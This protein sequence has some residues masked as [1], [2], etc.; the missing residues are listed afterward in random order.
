MSALDWFL[1]IVINGAIVAFGLWHARNTRNSVDWFLGAKS[2]PWW[3]V[4]LS[5]FA[6]AVDS[7]DYVAVAGNAYKDGLIY[8]SAWWLGLSIGWCTV[9][10]LVFL[11]M[12]RA[13]MY[14]NV[15]YLEFRFGPV[16]R[17]LSV[18]IQIQTRT[19]VMGIV[20]YS[21]FLTFSS[22]TGWGQN[23]WWL[24][25]GIAIGAAAYTA[26]GGVKSV[27]L[28][29][30]IQ[31]VVMLL[32]AVVLWWTV[33]SDVGGWSGLEIKLMEHIETGRLAADTG[34]AMTHVGEY[35]N[36]HVPPGLVVVGYI[37]VL[38]GYC[39]I[40]H[41]QSMRLLAARSVWDMKIAA[42]VAATVTALV[43]WFNV[44]LGILGRA[45]VPDLEQ[46]DEIFPVLI[47][48][49][50]PMMQAGLLGIVVAGLLAGGLST[51]DSIGSALA[52]VFIRDF[53][54]RFFVKHKD[55]RHYLGAS[56]VVTVVVIAISF[57]YTPFLGDGMINNYLK[58]TGV[59]VVP[60][61][62]IYLLGV[63]TP[64]ARR[65]ATWGL[66]I[67]IACGLTRFIDPLL[68][69]L[70]LEAL[71]F[72]WTNVWWGY[73]WSVFATILA[74]L[75]ASFI[76]GW[77]TPEELSGL[78]MATSGQPVRS[79]QSHHAA[80]SA[81]STWLDK[82]RT[83]APVAKE[84]PNGLQLGTINWYQSPLLWTV[85]LFGMITYLNLFAFW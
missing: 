44:T 27:A 64:V 30:A 50:L 43:L 77:A 24:V 57:A 54:A 40:N 4:G 46:S 19:N 55:D 72:W 51:F 71:P 53:Y 67:G 18:F 12:Y 70:G 63:L 39:I 60:L 75:V 36:A 41:S 15:E 65:S 52:S 76:L 73:I 11:P 29:D 10:N 17:V 33:F 47:E 26:T 66:I 74:M 35:T 28:T 82:S 68:E 3:L 42:V 21:L 61:M 85:I 20:A 45:V 23:T 32:A 2:L 58:L 62:M 9:A 1:V 38:T 48:Q 7:G 49:Y 34:A 80:E 14:T 78:T 37:I 25:V 16:A 5:M 6:T 69:S 79:S 59:A 83:E 8:I 13:G 22:L 81:S 56:R 31:S 84:L